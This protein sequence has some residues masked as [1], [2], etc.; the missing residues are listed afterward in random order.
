M[1]LRWPQRIITT[2][3]MPIA[4]I[5]RKSSSH[6]RSPQ[7]WCGMSCEISSRNVPVVLS[8]FIVSVSVG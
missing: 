1:N 6:S 4:F 8:P 7:F 3:S 2:V 5:R